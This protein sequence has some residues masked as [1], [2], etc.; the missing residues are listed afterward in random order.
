MNTDQ[1]IWR[2][3]FHLAYF[4]H[5]D[6]RTAFCV[7]IHGMEL[8]ALKAKQQTER[9]G[10]NLMKMN[11]AQLFQ[12]GLLQASEFYERRQ[13]FDQFGNG[14][15]SLSG[16]WKQSLL[17]QLIDLAFSIEGLT[18]NN[19]SLP[20]S[21][22]DL[23]I[24]YIKHLVQVTVSRN[25]YQVMIGVSQFLYR[26]GV[27]EMGHIHMLIDPDLKRGGV[28]GK[29]YKTSRKR[30][31]NEMVNRFGNLL[32][33]RGKGRFQVQERTL[34]LFAL[35]NDSLDQLALW[36][37]EHNLFTDEPHQAHALIHPACYEKVIKQLQIK[38]PTANLTIPRFVLPTNQNHFHRPNRRQPPD[39]TETQLRL[40]QEIYDKLS[41]RRKESE[42][43]L[44]SI[45]VDGVERAKFDP[46]LTNAAS[47]H[48]RFRPRM[49]EVYSREEGGDLLLASCWMADFAGIESGK[50]RATTRAE[51]G[52]RVRF[53][54][55]FAEDSTTVEISYRET[56]LLRWLALVRKRFGKSV[57]P[58]SFHLPKPAIALGMMAIAAFAVLYFFWWR[59]KPGALPQVVKQPSPLI[60]PAASP[61]P[62]APPIKPDSEPPLLAEN[63]SKQQTSQNPFP[64]RDGSQRKPGVPLRSVS[65]L[66]VQ[67]LGEDDFSLSLRKAL[68]A[69]LGQSSFT[70]EEQIGPSTDAV[71]QRKPKTNKR[72]LTLRLVNRTGEVLWQAKFDP[73]NAEQIAEQ[74]A[75][76]LRE[77][78]DQEKQKQ[79]R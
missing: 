17:E 30:I 20:L 60:V 63:R 37:T 76:T 65:R 6:L 7:L 74:V 41:K 79:S 33:L 24:R 55:A 58:Y 62:N 47:C 78:A 36:D 40:L 35:V 21:E 54:M 56:K 23:T 72:H 5:C 39:L 29:S 38:D 64:E 16:E 49:I 11:A 70:V 10:A 73:R 13:E 12:I 69:A 59:Q 31:W 57:F 22:E 1:E 53:D 75:K 14:D 32:A 44:L 61:L 71:L 25:A 3:A 28:S 42:P 2:R 51:G 8:A 67:S 45:R 66:Y 27:K 52:Q 26:H 34:P 43:M 50:V 19:H 18:V 46:V 9:T 4:I 68:N 77:A 15:E 48:L